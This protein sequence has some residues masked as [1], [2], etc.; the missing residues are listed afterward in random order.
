VKPATA[1]YWLACTLFAAVANSAVP[2][3]LP[4]TA[5]SGLDAAM[6]ERMKLI[7]H[8][9]AQIA[10]LTADFEQ[11][12]QTTLLKNPIVSIGSVWSRRSEMLWNT[13]APE[14]TIMH[15][16]ENQIIL[17]YRDQKTAEIYPVSGPLARL[18]ASPVPR[19][20]DLLRHFSFTDAS[21]TDLGVDS[22]PDQEA[23]LLTPTDRD[24]SD[25][26]ENV[27]VLIDAKA[28]FILAFKMTDSD[29]E[30]TLLR[31]SNVKIN[32]QFDDKRL[33]LELPADVK[34]VH[35]L[36]NVGRQP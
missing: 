30:I 12:K 35:P 21:S 18:T 2:S 1:S 25:H 3:T 28:G 10:D 31:F 19:L 9:A 16:D 13:R 34:T 7:D 36:E 26:V 17:Y 8:A 20:A 5:P 6:W 23:F 32:T 27:I 14:P 11:Q 15:V 4:T 22:E 33:R 24:I 29:G